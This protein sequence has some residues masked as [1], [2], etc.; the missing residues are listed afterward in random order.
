MGN[1][2]GALARANEIRLARA[3]LKRAIR[4]GDPLLTDVIDPHAEIPNRDEIEKAIANMTV[5]ELVCA[6][7][8]VGSVR[9]AKLWQGYSGRPKPGL[10]VRDLAEARRVA[11]AGYLRAKGVGLDRDEAAA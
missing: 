2:E 10:R 3:R 8:Y 7:P 11:F 1:W 5:E 6:A 4:A 9:F